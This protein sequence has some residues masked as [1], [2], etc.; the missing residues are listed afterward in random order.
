MLPELP[1]LYNQD[2]QLLL[3]AS[4]DVMR[5]KYT[6]QIKLNA[7][8]APRTLVPHKTTLNASACAMVKWI[9][10]SQMELASLAVMVTFQIV[11]GPDVLREQLSQ[12][13]KLE[14]HVP[15]KEKFGALT[16]LNAS[17]ACHTLELRDRTQSVSPT[18]A[19]STKSSHGSEH[20]LTAL[21]DLDQTLTEEAVLEHPHF[22]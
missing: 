19:V 9:L 11:P 1:V 6:T 20:V 16:E 10:L 8:H 13:I 3:E 5:N 12:P 18:N 2:H 4:Q 7:F 22:D 21:T 14:D 15:E 17:S